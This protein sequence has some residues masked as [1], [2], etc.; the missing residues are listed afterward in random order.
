MRPGPRVLS[1]HLPRSGPVSCKRSQLSTFWASSSGGNFPAS[2]RLFWKVPGGAAPACPLGSH[3]LLSARMRGAP[4]C[5]GLIPPLPGPC[6]PVCPLPF[7]AN[8]LPLGS[9]PAKPC[10]RWGNRPNRPHACE[11]RGDTVTLSPLR[12]MGAD[13]GSQGM[14]L[15]GRC[16]CPR[17]GSR[18]QRGSEEIL[19]LEFWSS[20]CF[21]CSVS[22]PELL[23]HPQR[24]SFPA[25]L[26]SMAYGWARASLSSCIGGIG[27]HAPLGAAERAR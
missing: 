11:P 21:P 5:A 20:A 22:D 13:M 12:W 23:P 24:S 2:R 18:W 26:H 19:A 7:P 15:P 9:T 16:C 27:S 6:P 14:G 1:P 3:A 8:N 25:Q 17:R 4:C 10:C